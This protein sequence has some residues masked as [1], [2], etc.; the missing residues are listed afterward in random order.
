M[1]RMK[2][3]LVTDSDI[4]GKRDFYEVIEE[5]LKAGCRCVQLREKNCLGKEF[6]QKAL[7]LREITKKYD[8][9][10]IIND[11]VD[12]AILSDADGV[13]VG[14]DDI[15]L[16]EVRKLMQ[17]KIIGVSANNVDEA[18]EAQ[19]NGADYIGVGAIFRTN[20]KLDANNVGIAILDDIMEKVNLPIVA[21][22]GLKTTN[23]NQIKNARI[24]GYAVV[25]DILAQDDIFA[26]TCEWMNIV[27]NMKA[28]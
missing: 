3:Y 26:K 17:G 15:P 28:M 4:I 19:A 5:S 10:F 27:C 11:R 18:I 25:S 6:L 23:V 22:G 21:I 14:Q 1:E 12:I 2:L 13:H 24:L 8:A 16:K 20:T 7:K 9:L